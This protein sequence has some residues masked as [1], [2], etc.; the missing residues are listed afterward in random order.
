MLKAYFSFVDDEFFI[1]LM[2]GDKGSP[3]GGVF[4]LSPCTPYPFPAAWG[5]FVRSGE[6]EVGIPPPDPRALVSGWKVSDRRSFEGPRSSLAS[7]GRKAGPPSGLVNDSRSLDFG[8]RVTFWDG[9]R[10]EN[11][12][13]QRDLKAVPAGVGGSRAA[14][15]GRG[16]VNQDKAT[17]ESAHSRK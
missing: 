1:D 11:S 13:N 17:F 16:L 14:R 12:S 10:I 15:D 4:P 2:Q 7:L 6:L 9:S 5:R 8:S 3:L